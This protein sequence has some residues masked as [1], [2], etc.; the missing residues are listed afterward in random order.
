MIVYCMFISVRI[1]LTMSSIWCYL[2]GISDLIHCKNTGQQHA[3]IMCGIAL[4]V[5]AVLLLVL[6]AVAASGQSVWA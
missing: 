2:G 1:H 6:L 3:C 4:I 5:L